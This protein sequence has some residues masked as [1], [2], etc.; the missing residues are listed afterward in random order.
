MTLTAFPGLIY[1]VPVERFLSP[2]AAR[3]ANVWF[4]GVVATWRMALYGIYLRRY[5]RMAILPLVVQLL[6]PVVVILAALTA[7]NLEHAVFDIMGGIQ[8]ETTSAD[9]AYA[10]VVGLTL[11]SVVIAP[12]L[13]LIYLVLAWRAWTGGQGRG[14]PAELIR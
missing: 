11:A 3:T 12:V 6:F 4:L 2:E 8:R 13:I 5:A 14:R 1:A 9:A 10:V 7:L